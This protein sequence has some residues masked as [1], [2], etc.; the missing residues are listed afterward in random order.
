METEEE[1]V[2]SIMET[3]TAGSQNDD[4]EISERF[5]RNLLR[6][7][8]APAIAKASMM[9]ALVTDECFQPLGELEFTLIRNNQ[10]E[11]MLPKIILLNDNSG[12]IFEK[13]GE[14]IPVLNSEEFSLGLK[15]LINRQLP[16]SK[17][18]GSKAVIFS[19]YTITH[20]KVKPST[21]N[22]INDFKEELVSTQGKKITVSVSAILDNPD[23]G[24]GYDWTTSN[25]PCSSEL[26]DEIKTNILRKE[27]GII[28]SVKP[29]IVT[30]GNNADN[31]T[32]RQATSQ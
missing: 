22:V 18:S 21:N 1:L 23:H 14:S 32:Q 2:Y 26:I 19:G 5:V 17:I 20:C 27:F 7:Y 13:N 3:A 15:S 10:F 31:Q 9:G 24:L 11:R 6:Q 16:K 30:D 28:L 12:V 25:Y 4:G 8:R 29:D